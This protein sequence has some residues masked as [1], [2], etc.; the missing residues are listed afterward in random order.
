[1]WHVT[2]RC[3]LRCP[4]CFASK[5]ELDTNITK[6]EHII[7]I[8]RA[9]GV[10]KVDIAGGEPLIWNGLP[11][12]VQT[13]KNNRFS[14]TVTTSGVG[15]EANRRW[16]VDRAGLFA[17]IIVSIDGP[18][19]A[20][21]DSLRR[22]PGAFAAAVDLIESLHRSQYVNLR[23]N[24]VLVKPLNDLDTLKRFA[25]AVSAL[26]PQEWC[27]IQPHPANKKP[28]FDQFALEQEAFLKAIEQLTEIAGS[29]RLTVGRIISR[30]VEQYTGYWV[31]YPDGALKRH[32]SGAEDCAAT[33]IFETTV[34]QMIATIRHHGYVVPMRS[35]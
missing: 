35:I 25:T 15:S 1:M 27:L 13:L 21:H 24:S 3:P 29:E 10:Q 26:R 4:Y 32:T 20:E 16:I 30:T 5:T 8:F 28:T 22:F 2:D 12:T 9:L 34:E 14:L 17:R 19:E 7:A 18:T 33:P 6:L 11:T 23:I 31:L